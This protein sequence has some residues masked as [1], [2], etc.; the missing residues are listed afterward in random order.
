MNIFEAIDI[1]IR[2]P[3]LEVQFIEPYEPYV[4]HLATEAGDSLVTEDG[5]TIKKE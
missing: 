3:E 5:I 2:R 4:M 1:V